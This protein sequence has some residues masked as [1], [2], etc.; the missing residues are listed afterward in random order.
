[1]WFES[2][3]TKLKIDTNNRSVIWCDNLNAISLSTNPILHSIT[4]HIEIDLNF[5]RE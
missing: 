1:M 4:K 5:I 2:P 3:L